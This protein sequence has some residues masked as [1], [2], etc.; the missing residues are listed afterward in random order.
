MVGIVEVRESNA[1]FY[2]AHARDPSC[3]CVFAGATG[4]IGAGALASLAHLLPAPTLYV[5]G[6]SEERFARQRNELEKVSPRAKVVFLK[7]Q[8]SLLADVDAECDRIAAAEEKV[9]YLCMSP[10]KLPF[11]GPECTLLRRDR[12]RGSHGPALLTT[13]SS[14]QR[15]P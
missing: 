13:Q 11:N 5:I 6:R 10:G 14:H 7:G 12:V 4:G 1:H 15:G 9:D 2:R 8:F 3:V